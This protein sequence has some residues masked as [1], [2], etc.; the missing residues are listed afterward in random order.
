LKKGSGHGLVDILGEVPD[1]YSLPDADFSAIGRHLSIE[2]SQK[3]CFA[4]AIGPNKP[5]AV[6][7]V[8]LDVDLMKKFSASDG[9]G[10]ISNIYKAHNATSVKKVLKTSL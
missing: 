2:K 4:R 5:D 10:E 8:H 6:A 9:K 7:G 1:P 3:G